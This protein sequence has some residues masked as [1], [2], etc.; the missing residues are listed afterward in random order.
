MKNEGSNKV[1]NQLAKARAKEA[2][3]KEYTPEHCESLGLVLS[4]HFEWDGLC[5]LKT[6]SAALEDSNFHSENEVIT[7]MITKIEEAI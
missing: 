7:D 1:L 3:V 4:S 6:L 2:F 5:I